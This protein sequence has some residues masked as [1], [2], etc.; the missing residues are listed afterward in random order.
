[1]VP[2]SHTDQYCLVKR[3]P[4][5]CASLV[6][7]KLWTPEFQMFYTSPVPASAI[8]ITFVINITLN[9]HTMSREYSHLTQ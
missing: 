3:V 5:Y 8:E 2:F 1:V 7:V 4:E 6:S 9:S